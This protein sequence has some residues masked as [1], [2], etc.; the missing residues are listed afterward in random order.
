MKIGSELHK[1]LF[2]NSFKESHIIFEP[3]ELP[4]PKLDDAALKRLRDVPFWEEALNTELAAG[5]KIERYLPMISDPLIYEA[6][7]LQG[8]EEARHGRLFKFMIQY[9]GIEIAGN[10]RAKL[11]TDIEQAFVDFGYGECVDSFLGFGLFKIAR[12]SGFLPEPM[13]D[14]FDLLLQE[15]ARHIVFFVNWIAYLQVNQGRG[16]SWLRGVTSLWNYGR[17][18]QSMMALVN[19]STESKG[20]DFA[21]TEINAFL[22]DFSLE[23]LLSEC[24]SENERRMSSFDDRLLQPQLLPMLSKVALSSLKLFDKRARTPLKSPIV[25]N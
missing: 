1:E 14:I 5:A 13:F 17:A 18:V 24:L 8:L 21:P 11:S 15:E 3:E 4:W 16:A 22:E 2:C 6:V 10:P 23:K 20:Q 19:G 9:Y 12:Q 7:A 25:N